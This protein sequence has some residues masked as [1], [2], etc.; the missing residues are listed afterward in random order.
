MSSWGNHDN[1]AN[2]PYWA[3]NSTLVSV[4]NQPVG[5]RP[6]AA[7]VASLYGNT[8]PDVYT[9]GETLGL[10]LVDTIEEFA[11]ADQVT[12][13]SI[14]QGGTQYM[15]A[16]AVTFSG[17]GGSS[18]AATASIS[19]GVVTNI[20][21]TNNGSSYETV[22]TVTIQAPFVTL[23]LASSSVVST[24]TY[25][26]TYTAHRW[27]TGDEVM[28]APNG[29]G[30]LRGDVVTA[31]GQSSAVVNTSTNIITSVAHPF[32]TGDEVYYEKSGSNPIG[33]LT[34]GTSYFAQRLSA[35][36]FALYD[37]YAH[38]IRQNTIP[39]GL[40]IIDLTGLGNGNADT[41]KYIFNTNQKYYVIK[42]G[43][44]DFQ[45]ARTYAFATAGSPTP[46]HISALFM[47]NNGSTFTLTSGNAT[48]DADKGLGAQDGANT[49]F[50]HAAHV[51][52][53]IK[54]TG[55]GG[56]AGRVQ[57]ETLVALANPI[58]DNSSDNI[59]LPGA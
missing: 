32:Q 50:T 41:F 14:I 5:T 19:G 39:D 23:N 16:P 6:T 44:N 49:G 45:L 57:W 51:G 17:G 54:K 1:A 36:T 33:G 53:N 59:T 38:V 22:P 55:E 7:N 34:T 46:I 26:F 56:R 18:A 43:A 12:D 47:P 28:Y 58:G 31:N 42:T 11:G 30:R 2:A 4:D 27:N 52:W 13:V 3:I 48:A 29:S 10:F 24:S 40:G 25:K 8:T 37:T 15:E 9:T 21:V 35:D 20:Q